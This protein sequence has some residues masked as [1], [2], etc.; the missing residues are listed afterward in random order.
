MRDYRSTSTVTD[1]PFE[2]NVGKMQILTIAGLIYPCIDVKR[3]HTQQSNHSISM[4]ELGDDVTDYTP[5]EKKNTCAV[6]TIILSKSIIDKNKLAI[7]AKGVDLHV[8]TAVDPYE[9]NGI[10]GIHVHHVNRLIVG[11][12]IAVTL[13]NR[14]VTRTRNLHDFLKNVMQTSDG[15]K[16]GLY[17]F[18]D[19]LKVVMLYVMLEKGYEYVAYQDFVKMYAV[20]DYILSSQVQN[21]VTRF[22]IIYGSG[23]DPEVTHMFV[24]KDAKDA[25]KRTVHELLSIDA[26]SSIAWQNAGV[27]TS[28]RPMHI[29]RYRAVTGIRLIR[30]LF[31]IRDTL[32]NTNRAAKFW[33]DT[34]FSLRYI[35]EHESCSQMLVNPMDDI[36]FAIQVLSMQCIPNWKQQRWSNTS[37]G[38]DF[39]RSVDS[40]SQGTMGHVLSYTSSMDMERNYNYTHN[41]LLRQW[42][43]WSNNLIPQ[44]SKVYDVASSIVI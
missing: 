12:D 15:N 14:R 6:C 17:D 39:I 3:A 24:S 8:F 13:L 41:V 31:H 33:F 32:D 43:L 16:F 11:D 9:F 7:M 20:N 37:S 38:D 4:I 29:L 36:V 27:R 34:H 44:G 1:D 40:I 25:A 26:S 21:L 18:I 19:T 22:G 35:Q 42:F 5:P 10:D 28:T 30:T 23:I 2:F